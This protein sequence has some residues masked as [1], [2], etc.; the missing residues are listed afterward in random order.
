MEGTAVLEDRLAR[1]LNDAL[2]S[3]EQIDE[4]A[5][6]EEGQDHEPTGVVIHAHGDFGHADR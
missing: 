6:F 2:L 4:I 5:Q 1:F 3:P